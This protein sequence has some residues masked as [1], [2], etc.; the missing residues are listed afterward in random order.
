M[1]Q[2]LEYSSLSSDGKASNVARHPIDQQPWYA[3]VQKQ[4][5]CQQHSKPI[6]FKPGASDLVNLTPATHCL[7]KNP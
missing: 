4:Q 5:E 6:K 7:P 2:N 1:F 3:D